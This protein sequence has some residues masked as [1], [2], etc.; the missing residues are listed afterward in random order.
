M[1]WQQQLRKLEEK[2]NFDIAIFYMQIIIKNIL[3]N[4]TF[5]KRINAGK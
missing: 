4:N 2:E 1:N 3:F 5:N